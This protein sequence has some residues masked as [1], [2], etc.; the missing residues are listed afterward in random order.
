[1]DQKKS[2]ISSLSILHLVVGFWLAKSVETY[3]YPNK[4]TKRPRIHVKCRNFNIFETKLCQKAPVSGYN[5]AFHD[6]ETKCAAFGGI[7]CRFI[8]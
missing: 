6:S 2:R 4:S 8:T 3:V 5:F 7:G 1:M